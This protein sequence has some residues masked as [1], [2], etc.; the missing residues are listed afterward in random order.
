M[1]SIRCAT[2]SWWRVAASIA[3]GGCVAVVAAAQGSPGP[4]GPA[5]E[6]VPVERTTRQPVASPGDYSVHLAPFDSLS[7]ELRFPCGEPLELPT[8][9][10]VAWVEGPARISDRLLLHNHPHDA[11]AQ[12]PHR[13]V[14]S[15][16]P[17]GTVVCD[18]AS[19]GGLDV[20]RHEVELRLLH[21]DPP[22]AEGRLAPEFGRRAA[23]AALTEPHQMPVGPVVAAL[24]E[25]ATGRYLGLSRPVTVAPGGSVRVSPTPPARDRSAL[26]VRIERHQAA[27][28]ARADDVEVSLSAP[29]AATAPPDHVVR[30][31]ER[32]YAF[33]FDLPPGQATL[34]VT[35]ERSSAT[36]EDLRLGP[37]A[38]VNLVVQLRPPA[39]LHGSIALPSDLEVDDATL[40]VTNPGSGA[41]YRTLQIEPEFPAEVTVEGLPRVPVAVA[42]DA[43]PWRFAA[44]ADLTAGEATV[45]LAPE[46]I[47]VS[48]TVTLAGEGA[49]ATVQFMT[50]KSSMGAEVASAHATDEHGRFEATLAPDQLTPVLLV[51]VG[52]S[53]PLWWPLDEP[54]HDGDVVDIDL[55]GR[56]LDVEVVDADTGHGIAGAT[57]AYGWT[58]PQGTGGRR[59]TADDEGKVLIPPVPAASLQLGVRAEGY[60]SQELTVDT[61]TL[62]Q[63]NVV[64]RMTTE[65]AEQRLHVLLPGGAP[66]V[67]AEVAVLPSVRSSPR[68]VG[69]ADSSGVVGLPETSTGELVVARHPAA[70]TVV[71]GAAT[72]VG[73]DEP[74]VQLGPPGGIVSLRVVEPSGEPVPFAP[75]VLWV[76]EH[77]LTDGALTWLTEAPPMSL[78]DGSWTAQH[79]G[80]GPLSVLFWKRTFD[81][82]VDSA[83]ASG[84]L[85]HRRVSI[86]APLPALLEVEAAL[87]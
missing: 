18:E 79:V 65:A 80:A 4:G 24:A 72:L 77:R 14:V 31:R 48:G 7:A 27:D 73:N 2:G 37:G 52:D 16:G 47:H 42:L 46:L 78:R 50:S 81:P 62:D 71:V 74:V 53:E 41:V 38:I 10:F 36:A 39:T 70:G 26:V 67:T 13:L 23:G 85:D 21:G 3:V 56:Q 66:A 17:A 84:A 75:A 86:V 44:D 32:L 40:S 8:G 34:L 87:P 76:G 6:V 68:W 33:W 20:G 43:G 15:V 30:G 69:H 63:D 25:S 28:D 9:S 12:A 64:V 51:S 5:F 11:V 55:E 19:L 1:G 49:A 45:I 29:G 83:A 82:A 22:Q 60:R 54:P 35:S 61:S 59:A 57:V 58:G